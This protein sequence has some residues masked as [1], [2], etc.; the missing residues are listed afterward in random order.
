[1]LA[2]L[3]CRFIPRNDGSA[4]KGVSVSLTHGYLR[5]RP[6]RLS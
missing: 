4:Y 1:M 2:I 3:Y 6:F 5:K